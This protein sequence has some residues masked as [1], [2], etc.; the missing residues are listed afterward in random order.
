MV[1]AT[2]NYHRYIPNGFPVLKRLTFNYDVQNIPTSVAT[3]TTYNFSNSA[4]GPDMYFG[5][6]VID[7]SQTAQSAS[8]ALNGP[9]KW[10]ASYLP[11][12][13]QARHAT[14]TYT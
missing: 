7:V 2:I 4:V 6:I 11:P 5:D 1:C 12:S 8:R 14:R 3:I 10:E 9:A 13:Y